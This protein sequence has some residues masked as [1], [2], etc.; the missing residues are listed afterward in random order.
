MILDLSFL[1]SAWEHQT[2][3][4]QERR[5]TKTFSSDSQRF[6]IVKLESQTIEFQGRQPKILSAALLFGELLFDLTSVADWVKVLVINGDVTFDV[7]GIESFGILKAQ[8]RVFD[9]FA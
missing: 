1:K 4:S 7:E 9:G 3:Y 8:K 6:Q 2:R 5:N